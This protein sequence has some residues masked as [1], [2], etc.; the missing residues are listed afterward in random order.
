M[1]FLILAI[2]LLS[3]N[4]FGQSEEFTEDDSTD[5]YT[6]YHLLGYK[7][8]S[9]EEFVPSEENIE[10]D[11]FTKIMYNPFVNNDV[12]DSILRWRESKGLKP[13]EFDRDASVGKMREEMTWTGMYL[14]EAEKSKV[15]LGIFY[16]EKPD[17]ECVTDIATQILDDSTIFI[18]N[19]KGKEKIFNTYLLSNRIKRIEVYYYQMSRKEDPDKEE[20][21][22]VV[23]IKKR[24]SLF[25]R[26]YQIF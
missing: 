6:E 9:D 3:F 8:W 15:T 22:L 4:L 25:A 11:K 7:P 24:F 13:I 26:P 14:A 5:Y 18:M 21:H 19:K 1:K 20:E 12:L 2:C 17:C 23:K 10:W 16:E